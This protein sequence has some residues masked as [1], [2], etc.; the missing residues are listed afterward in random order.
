MIPIIC[1][2]LGVLFSFLICHKDNRNI[3][4]LSLN[5]IKFAK[6]TQSWFEFFNHKWFFDKNYNNMVNI[7]ILEEIV[8]KLLY[9]G[10]T[11]FWESWYSVGPLY[12]SNYL[13]NNSKKFSTSGFIHHYIALMA[14]TLI[15]SLIFISFFL[16]QT[17]NLFSIP[18]FLCA[19]IIVDSEN[20][21]WDD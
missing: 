12:F 2:I 5:K 18:N 13:S 1:T 17:Y 20:S 10:Y 14:I 21:V 4:Y 19:N 3:L 7:V 8:E 11:C 9:N 6:T 16:N 15:C